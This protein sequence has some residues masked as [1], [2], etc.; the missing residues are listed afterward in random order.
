ME[1]LFSRLADAGHDTREISLGG[2]DDED[3]RELTLCLS[4]GH[5]GQRDVITAQRTAVRTLRWSWPGMRCARRR[6]ALSTQSVRPQ[7]RA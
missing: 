3:V 1:S 2:L 4:D 7:R 6:M 5:A